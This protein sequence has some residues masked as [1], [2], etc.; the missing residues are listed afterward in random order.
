MVE[1]FRTNDQVLLSWLVALLKDG[2][3][4]AIVLD[5]HMSVLEGSLGILQRRL[6][7]IDDDAGR[8]RRLFDQ[9]G[10]DLRRA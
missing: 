10:V 7:V 8:A 9:A 4:E 3:I 5:R 2:D 6:M 1:L